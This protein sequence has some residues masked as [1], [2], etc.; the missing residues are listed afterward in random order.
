[1]ALYVGSKLVSQKINTGDKVESPLYNLFDFKWTDH[2][3]TDPSWINANDFEWIDGT[4]YTNAFNELFNEYQNTSSTDETEDTISYKRTPKGF[5]IAL[6]DQETVITTKYNDKG[7]AWYYILDITNKKFKLPRTKYGFEGLRDSV[8]KDIEES[9]PNITGKATGNSDPAARPQPTGAFYAGEIAEECG[10]YSGAGQHVPSLFSANKSSSVYQDNAHVQE[11]ATQ[12][13]LYFYVTDSVRTELNTDLSDFI[14]QTKVGLDNAVTLDTRQT[15]SGAKKFTGQ[16]T[17]NDTTT[18]FKPTGMYSGGPMGVSILGLGGYGDTT[19][20]YAQFKK[21]YT[22]DT[23]TTTC[24]QLDIKNN[25]GFRINTNIP[26]DSNDEQVST[27]AWVTTKLANKQDILVSGT[28]IKTVNDTS[29]LGSGNIEIKASGSG[30]PTGTII[31]WSTATAPEGYLICDGSAISRTTYANL[32]AV[33]GTLYGSGDGNSTFNIP[34]VVGRFLKGGT[35]GIINTESLPNIT[36]DFY[37]LQ[38]P[39]QNPSGA[40]GTQYL[41]NVYKAPNADNGGVGVAFNA[42]LSSAT[43]QNNAKVQPDNMEVV[44]SIKY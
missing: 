20:T 30:V 22:D 34:N 32:F 3:L 39:K 11:Y 23:K 8:G 17:F 18:F 43:Y 15:I 6:N 13:Y 21:Q 26:A 19:P 33:I 42:S 25:D 7:L 41:S 27:T 28:N 44:Y 5:K 14:N 16:N 38:Y 36:G 9:L 1:M 2:L 31:A 24:F 35:A 12:M 40:F 29:L 10:L 4:V 37:G